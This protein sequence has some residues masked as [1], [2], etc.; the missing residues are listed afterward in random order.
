MQRPL[1]HA[2]TRYN[3]QPTLPEGLFKLTPPYWFSDFPISCRAFPN[4]HIQRV[5]ARR[6]VGISPASWLLSALRVHS[7]GSPPPLIFIDRGWAHLG[8]AEGGLQ[9]EGSMPER[10]ITG[11][12]LRPPPPSARCSCSLFLYLL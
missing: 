11:A 6:G 8:S 4:Q 2:G 12:S 9:V 3:Q 5:R 7:V 10:N 1:L